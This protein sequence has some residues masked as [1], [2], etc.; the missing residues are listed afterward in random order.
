[1][2]GALR[3]LLLR[4]ARHRAAAQIRRIAEPRYAVAAGLGL[5]YLASL[6]ARPP[7]ADYASAPVAEIALV[8]GSIGLA[9]WTTWMWTLGRLSRIVAFAPA[10]LTFL[11]AGPV[12]T[13]RLLGYKL[14][15]AQLGI[16][17]N[18]LLWAVFLGWSGGGPEA[19]RAFPAA[20]LL[21]TTLQLHH[22]GATLVRTEPGDAP[23]GRRWPVELRAA[24]AATAA[25]AL[26]VAI[27]WPIMRDGLAAGVDQ[28]LPSMGR[29]LEQ[30]ALLML[31]APFRAVAAPLAA[32]SFA[33]FRSAVPAALAV[34]AL[35]VAW[36]LALRVRFRRVATE[37]P[38][39]GMSRS[40]RQAWSP[41]L[42]ALPPEGRAAFALTWKNVAAVVRRRRF[43]VLL[44]GAVAVALAAVVVG[45][46]GAPL[47][48]Q[49]VA[50]VAGVWAAAFTLLG[51]QWVRNDLRT[52]LRHLDSLRSWP[53]SGASIVAAEVLASTLVLTAAQ[54]GT[55]AVG[56]V[57]A[58]GSG[59]AEAG[60]WL[61]TAVVGGMAGLP[62]VNWLHL[63]VHNGLAVLYPGWVPL[64]PEPRTGI[65]G[66]GQ[67]AIV[68]IAGLGGVILLLA[69]A[70]IG[71]GLVMASAA[72]LGVPDGAARTGAVIAGIPIALAVSAL[73][74]R[75]LGERVTL[76]EPGDLDGGDQARG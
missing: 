61:G 16:V 37:T 62:V 17:F 72:A 40:R 2:S 52:D 21:L 46:S 57:A 26:A 5:V 73:V 10:E 22:L 63:L 35:H 50:V 33:A 56:A 75:W 54:L 30:P 36:V 76:L 11:L 12:G 29:A 47:V 71:A 67:Q 55:I 69:P 20:W 13:T 18:A 31:L 28:V 25:L 59:T 70:G 45:W 23:R 4:T 9:L 8:G 64:G 1:M 60:P 68:L 44:A 74:V 7:R 66:L 41:P 51:P 53:L 14:A 32:P 49:V 6:M 24:T 19:W 3:Y 15:R 43:A 34:L 65:E 38:R 58:A 42:T 39:T 48:P 27:V